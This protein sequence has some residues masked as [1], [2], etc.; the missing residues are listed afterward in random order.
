[1]EQYEM[2]VADVEDT[3]DEL[4][5][6]CLELPVEARKLMARAYRRGAYLIDKSLEPDM[7]DG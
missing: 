2:T 1:M 7:Y 6:K 4:A 3:L 5:A